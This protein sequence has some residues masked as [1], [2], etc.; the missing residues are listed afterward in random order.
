MTNIEYI[1]KLKSLN[2]KMCR[3]SKNDYQL[4]KEDQSAQFIRAIA[5]TAISIQS[6]FMS[7]H[8]LSLFWI[9][10]SLSISTAALT[11][12]SILRYRKADKCRELI[13]SG[14]LKI[15]RQTNKPI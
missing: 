14:K 1:E 2:K 11:V 5:F 7:F 13:A 15:K 8:T 6:L 3:P 10:I 9:Q 4:L 12:W